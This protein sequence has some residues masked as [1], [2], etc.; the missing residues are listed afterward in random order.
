MDAS[1]VVCRDV[2]PEEIPD[3]LRLLGFL[4]PDVPADELERR[5]RGILA[6]HPHYRLHGV[7]Q[8]ERLI[9]VAGSW[10][11]TR[12]WCGKYLE[13]DNLVVDPE[14]RNSGAGTTL[15][16]HLEKL[17]RESGC[18]MLIL[19]SYT[20]NY[21]SHR[22]YHRMGYEIWGFHFVKPIGEVAGAGVLP[23]SA[24]GRPPA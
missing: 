22:L 10:T 24:T 20:G 16:S 12:I 23:A 7:W 2:R 15:I 21:A 18:G 4:N 3:A 19:D 11:G 17:A 14:S 6:G 9:G 1:P 5:L 8:S 13:I